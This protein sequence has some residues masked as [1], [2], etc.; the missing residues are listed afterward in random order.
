MSGQSPIR[1]Q[2]IVKAQEQFFAHGFSKVTTDELAAALGISKKTLYQHFSSKDELVREAIYAMREEISGEIGRIV[3]GPESDF[4]GKL[5]SVMGVL[6]RKLARVQR[7]FF[8]DMQKKAPELWRE[9]EEFRRDRILT[10]FQELFRQGGASGMLREHVDPHLFVMMFLAI[11]QGIFNPSVLAHLPMS[12][13][14]AFDTFITV[15][16]EGV[17]SDDARARFRDGARARDTSGRR[18]GS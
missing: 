3:A 2:I 4:A 7:P 13:G 9:I 1:R 18:A 8:E 14:K 10:L 17:L 15:M 6:A 12:A 16:L 11:V 5:R